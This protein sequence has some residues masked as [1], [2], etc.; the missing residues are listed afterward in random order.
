MDSG[1]ENEE[2]DIYYFTMQ[3]AKLRL[4]TSIGQHIQCNSTQCNSLFQCNIPFFFFFLKSILAC[5]IKGHGEVMDKALIRPNTRPLC[6]YLMLNSSIDT[7][8]PPV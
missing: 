6:N 4:M 3:Y 5:E 7:L 8:E 2:Y 1:P